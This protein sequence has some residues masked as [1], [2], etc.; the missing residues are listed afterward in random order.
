MEKTHQEVIKDESES[1]ASKSLSTRVVSL[2]RSVVMLSSLVLAGGCTDKKYEPESLPVQ[3]PSTVQPEPP[4]NGMLKKTLEKEPSFYFGLDLTVTQR[5][6]NLPLDKTIYVP[7]GKDGLR[8]K[9]HVMPDPDGNKNFRESM[10]RSGAKYSPEE[11]KRTFRNLHPGH[12]IVYLPP[13]FE[14]VDSDSEVFYETEE[15][16][17][18]GSLG[19]KRSTKIEPLETMN[20]APGTKIGPMV[21]YLLRYEG[22]MPDL[23]YTIKFRLKKGITFPNPLRV[24]AGAFEILQGM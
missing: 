4:T 15:L 24:R 2:A 20:F 10:T 3:A 9:M 18:N 11:E 22:R 19:E 23:T 17:G 8:V 5:E 16:N 21:P 6:S 1:P 7:K 12:F 14:L 13:V